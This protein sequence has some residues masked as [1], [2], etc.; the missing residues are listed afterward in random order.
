MR[1]YGVT[2]ETMVRYLVVALIAVLSA[3]P[4]TGD[5]SGQERALACDR[6]DMYHQQGCPHCQRAREFLDGLRLQMPGL[7]VNEYEVDQPGVWDRFIQL[8]ERFG[9]VR[10]G[11]PALHLCGRFLVGYDARTARHVTDIL[12]GR[13][14]QET[15]TAHDMTRVQLPLLGSVGLEQVGLPL[16]TLAIGLLDGFN[17]CAMWVLLFLLTLLVNVH[18]RRRMLLVAGTFVAVSG[19][20]YFAFM[21]AWLNL[22]LFMGVSGAVRWVIGA[23]AITIGVVHVKDFLAPGEGVSLSIPQAARPGIYA[24]VRNIVQARNLGVALALVTVLA[25]LVN[26][27]ELLC[28]AG[29][30]ALYTRILTLQQLSSASYYAYLGLYNL[31]YVFDDALMVGVVVFTLERA[32]LKPD[33]GRW[34]KLVSGVTVLTLGVVLLVAPGALF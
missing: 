2:D 30:P 3:L 16:F 32:R 24:R 18:S 12:T 23:A 22:F 29:L 31:A 34:L 13:A 10:P 19:A 20:V 25:V 33:Q 21:A 9:I 26:M 1:Q 28:T 27:V 14:T 17:P 8:N 15:A 5:A 11:V 4:L 7:T 6:V